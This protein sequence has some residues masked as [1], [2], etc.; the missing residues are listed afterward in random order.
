MFENLEELHPDPILGLMT[1]H[2][3]DASLK[4]IDLGVGVYRDESGATP[5][6]KSVLEAQKIRHET[7]Q[8]KSYIGPP[9]T[10]EFNTLTRKLMFGNDNQA[11][12]SNRIAGVQTP[13]GCGALRVAAELIKRARPKTTIWVSDPTWANHQP[14]L[15]N[16]GLN[17]KEY[18]YYQ[19]SSRSLNTDGLLESLS[20]VPAGDAVLIHGC[21][22]NPSGVDLEPQHWEAI[23]DLAI[24]QG[25]TP[26]IDLAYQGLGDSLDEDA[27]G[28]KILS[29][30]C[31]EVIVASSYSKNFGLYRERVGSLQIVSPNVAQ[32]TI[33]QSQLGSVVRGIYSMPP[34]HGAAI[35]ETILS[36]KTLKLQW[37]EELSTMRDRINLLRKELA[38]RLTREIDQDFSFIEKQKG[39]FSFLGID[40]NQ[41]ARLQ[42]EFAIYM[43]DSSR[44]NVAGVNNSN[45]DY[46]VESMTTILKN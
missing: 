25:F 1:A 16:A 7:E 15:G 27:I 44:I 12:K 2:R 40:T 23:A 39:M 10:P 33:V 5:I 17:L 18:A 46:F 8:T 30:R 24:N 22:H 31:P 35:V 20:N 38:N 41:V 3:N 14:L 37:V 6:M 29:E 11:E 36:D 32:T 45:I 26:F 34:A 42:K 4:K 21:C 19:K 28:V 43:V 13:G 9:G